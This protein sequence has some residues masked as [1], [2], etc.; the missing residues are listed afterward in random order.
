MPLERRAHTLL[1]AEATSAGNLINVLQGIFQHSPSSDQAEDFDGL[2]R[3]A[4]GFFFI[5]AGE[6]STAHVHLARQQIHAK[7]TATEVVSQPQVQAV[8]NAAPRHSEQVTGFRPWSLLL[9]HVFRP[10]RSHHDSEQVQRPVG[11]K[12]TRSMLGRLHKKISTAECDGLYDQIAQC[13]PATAAQPSCCLRKSMNTRSFCGIA[14]R[15]K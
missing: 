4:T 6:V 15:L 11:G 5:A 9:C 10:L 8:E 13:R 12:S 3:C 2:G 1:V 14:V 7:I